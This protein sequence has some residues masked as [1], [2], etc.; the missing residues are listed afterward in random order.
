MNQSLVK[1]VLA[2]AF[3]NA[4]ISEPQI[5]EVVNKAVLTAFS[6]ELEIQQNLQPNITSQEKITEDLIDSYPELTD[7]VGGVKIECEIVKATTLEDI[8]QRLNALQFKP[9]TQDLNRY[10]Y[11]ILGANLASTDPNEAVNSFV[12]GIITDYADYGFR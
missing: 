2:A 11:E 8:K 7:F 5:D 4:T 6:E 1:D 9:D 10:P 12:Y 3:P